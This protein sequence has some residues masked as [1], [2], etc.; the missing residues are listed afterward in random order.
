MS[1]QTNEMASRAI[2]WKHRRSLRTYINSALTRPI[3]EES[4]FCQT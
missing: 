1:L 3:L 2:V 4:C